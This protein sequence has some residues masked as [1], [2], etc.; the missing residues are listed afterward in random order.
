MAGAKKSTNAKIGILMI[1]H[2]EPEVF[3][4]EVWT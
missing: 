3:E 4:E 2:G 1:G